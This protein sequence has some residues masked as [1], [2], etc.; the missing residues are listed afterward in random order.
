MRFMWFGDEYF[1]DC[2]FLM[3]RLGHE[4]TAVF[5]YKTDI[6]DSRINQ[7]CRMLC[8]EYNTNCPSP[9][10]L[11]SY[12]RNCDFVISASYKYLIPITA[13]C[14]QNRV[15]IH[16][17]PLPAGRGPTPRPWLILKGEKYA[18]I[19]IHQLSENYDAGDILL[20]EIYEIDYSFNS[21]L[22]S[23]L[24]KSIAQK[25]LHKYILEYDY[26]QNNKKIQSGATYWRRITD[27]ERT[28]LFFEN[29]ETIDAKMRAFY[30]DYVIID[31]SQYSPQKL[32]L[33][34]K[35]STK[36]DNPNYIGES[37]YILGVDW[38]IIV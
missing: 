22:L 24:N 9:T 33:L 32:I 23:D 27:R 16:P 10:L 4:C 26:Y 14:P 18:G 17:S 36:Y 20:Q 38:C 31:G 2:F 12:F 34:K 13:S 11:D 1:S 35:S 28:I 29:F 3:V 7:Y 6:S 25:L 21:Q 5:N 30:D 37:R 8:I 15:N 19:T